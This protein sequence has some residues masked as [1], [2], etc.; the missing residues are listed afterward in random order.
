M[1][2]LCEAFWSA[3]QQVCFLGIRLRPYAFAA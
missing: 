3:F 2:L 1:H